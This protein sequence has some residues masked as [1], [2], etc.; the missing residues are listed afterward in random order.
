MTPPV[1]LRSFPLPV[2]HVTAVEPPRDRRRVASLLFHDCT[3]VVLRVHGG[4]GDATV[5][6]VWCHGGHGG[7]ASIPPQIGPTRAG[8]AETLN[9]FKTS[10]VL[11]VF[12]SATAINDGTTAEPR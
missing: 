8:T 3:V 4:N 6:L 11:T 1:D 10:A 12:R 5:V 2:T 7:A 9:M